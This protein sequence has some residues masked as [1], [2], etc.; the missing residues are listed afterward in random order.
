MI[1][2]LISK[3]SRAILNKAGY[4]VG[5]AYHG[6]EAIRALS[7]E[8][9]D[10]VLMDIQMPEMDG[11]ECTGIIRNKNSQVFNHNVPII[12]MTG[13]ITAEDRKH[14][15]EKGMDDFIGKPVQKEKLI[16]IIDKYIYRTKVEEIEAQIDSPEKKV[17]NYEN[18]LRQLSGDEE[19]L[20]DL[21]NS[22]LNITPLQ[23]NEL[24]KAVNDKDIALVA[25]KSHSI[26]GAFATAEAHSL[27]NTALEIEKIANSKKYDW[28]ILL[29][30]MDR[31]EKEFA[32]FKLE[33]QKIGIVDNLKKN[34]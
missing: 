12:A 31:L 5:S 16:A 2:H 15:I 1:I 20:I 33:L 24:K 14:C 3:I 4:S 29:L 8:S 21:M 18:L 23:V 13:N 19:L 32:R 11:F 22:F 17:F 34:Y 30:L 26:K 25:R 10:V 7:R 9:Y 28:E 6:K 27:M